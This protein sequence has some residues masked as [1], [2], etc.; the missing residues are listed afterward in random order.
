MPTNPLTH[1]EILELVE[2]FARRGR[3]VDLGLTD[4]PGRRLVFKPVEH[5]DGPLGSALVEALALENPER[6]RYRLIRTLTHASGMTATLEMGGHYPG[7][8]LEQVDA[9]PPG[10]QFQ[11]QDGVPIARNYRIVPDAPD[12]SGLA[13]FRAVLRGAEARLPQLTLLF[14]S[15]SG[16]K[17]PGEINLVASPE[18]PM[19][20]PDDLLA[21][22]G[23]AWRPM[24]LVRGGWRGTLKLARREPKRTADAETKLAMTV[25]HLVRTL[26]EPPSRFHPRFYWG[27]WR[28]VARKTLGL[29]LVL[30]SL[31]AGP[32]IL[33]MD[34]PR[35]S[36]WRMLAFNMPPFL[37]LAV[38]LIPDL[39]QMRIPRP[40]R[41]L[42]D[43]AWVPV[44]VPA[45]A[46]N[47]AVPE[48][49]QGT[50]GQP[51]AQTRPSPPKTAAPRRRGW[52]ARRARPPAPKAAPKRTGLLRSLWSLVRR[53][54]A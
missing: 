46:S 18:H 50:A 29:M 51:V 41:P 1:H 32:L 28:V 13:V 23:W 3:H 48:Q 22:L 5:V 39:P 25:R 24:R 30:G 14:D 10:R 8:L 12:Q 6:G 31:A 52:L 34:L 42:P 26:A 38:F 7:L 33:V 15:Q 11:V 49:T 44:G 16:F 37:M 36:V 17:L 45:A 40:P 27:R 20:P 35:D 19:S 43:D 4:R 2:P 53:R 9:F 47:L 21:V 54:R